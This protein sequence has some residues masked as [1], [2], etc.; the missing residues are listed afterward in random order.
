MAAGHGLGCSLTD[1]GCAFVTWAVP[2]W[3]E[4]RP[5]SFW[6]ATPSWLGLPLPLQQKVCCGG[7]AGGSKVGD[8]AWQ[9]QRQQQRD[10]DGS[11]DG[12][13]D[14][15]AAVGSRNGQRW[16]HNSSSNDSDGAAQWHSPM[17]QRQQ[18]AASGSVDRGH[19]CLWRK[20]QHWKCVSVS[21]G[22][23][24]AAATANSGDSDGCEWQS[25]K[26]VSS[27]VG[28]NGAAATPKLRGQPSPG[29]GGN[30]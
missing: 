19:H 18:V 9:Q 8:I 6:L 3:L 28:S 10:S 11:G 16:Q 13:G 20:Q 24:G 7:S 2:S 15:T 29:R 27:S 25:W 17:A 23:N 21:I 14:G 1:L 30:K 22:S 5:C 26:R 4:L 12:S